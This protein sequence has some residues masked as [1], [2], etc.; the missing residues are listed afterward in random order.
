M[1]AMSLTDSEIRSQPEVWDRALA[2][3]DAVGA[4]LAEKGERVLVVGCG[5]SAFVALALADLRE[6]A[7]CGVT[8]WAYA[9]EA[10]TGR[11]Y[12]RVVA[13]TRSGTTTEVLDL[14]A[15]VGRGSRRSVV[16][17]VVGSPVEAVADD[18]VHLALADERSVV[19]TRFPTT[20]VLLARAA[21]GED[22]SA[23]PAACA[24][25][26]A[27]PLPFDVADVDHHVYLGRGWTTGLA[28]EAA[29]K[30][31][32]AAQA[33]SES[34]PALDYRHGP[35]AVAGPRSAV[36]VLGT[37]PEGLVD[38]V[39]VTGARTVVSGED[40]LVQ[41]VLA[42]RVAVALAGHRGL[43]PDR[44]RHLTRSVVLSRNGATP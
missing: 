21:L 31:R 39:A 30:I 13:L 44:P 34:Y 14:L 15:A 36:W 22:V 7:G 16:T 5:T 17:G 26:L 41:L 37:P 19:Q 9:S 10:P 23:L 42:Q 33:W 38:D 6:R 18:V 3:T 27:G 28:H 32:E 4:V 1:A 2:H 8:D 43:D 24:R 40:P 11:G 35:V 20:T 29:L 12:D 25:V